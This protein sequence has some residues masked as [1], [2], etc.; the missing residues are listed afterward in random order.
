MNSFVF[1]DEIEG[2]EPRVEIPDASLTEKTENLVKKVNQ[3]FYFCLTTQA[4]DIKR[5]D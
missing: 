2:F 5:E 3:S 1:S 4:I